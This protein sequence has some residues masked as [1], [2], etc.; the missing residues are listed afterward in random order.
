M[1]LNAISNAIRSFGL[2]MLAIA[3]S[4][5]IIGDLSWNNLNKGLLAMSVFVGLLIGMTLITNKFEKTVDSKNIK[6][7][8]K[9]LLGFSLAFTVVAN[10]I[11][12]FAKISNPGALW[13]GLAAFTVMAIVFVGLVLAVDTIM[14][15]T[16]KAGVIR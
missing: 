14:K 2:A 1:N 10:V 11:S 3:I 8:G 13:N 9:S 12:K 15:L 4:F 7:F 5:K 16:L 6:K